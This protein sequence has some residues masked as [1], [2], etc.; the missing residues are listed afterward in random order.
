MTHAYRLSP[1]AAAELDAVIAY[2][3]QQAGPSV[4]IRVA[5]EFERAFELLATSPHVG[6]RRDDLTSEPVR[7]WT[8]YSYLVVYQPD[9]VPL[10]IA[11][12]L[13]G[14][15]DLRPLFDH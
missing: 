6:R 9:A 12:V 14:A 7:F 3:L 5:E 8:V 4:A 13:H 2:Y 15:R 11:R 1:Q 10:V